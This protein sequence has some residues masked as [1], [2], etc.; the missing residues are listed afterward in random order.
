M[1]ARIDTLLGMIRTRPDDPRLHFGL[2]LEQLN[3]GERD[4]GIASLRRYLELTDDE[5]NAWGR[6]GS[7]LREAGRDD[8]AREAFERGI[9][10]AERH[11]HPTM[12]EDFRAILEGW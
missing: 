4:A 11:R 12:A 2:A 10:A 3:A 6:L 8:E 5:G 1:T 7:A 9:E